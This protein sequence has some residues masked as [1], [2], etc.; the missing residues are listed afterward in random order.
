MIKLNSIIRT[1][2]LILTVFIVFQ[3]ESNAAETGIIKGEVVDQTTGDPLIGARIFVKGTKKGAVANYDGTYRII[4]VPVGEYTLQFSYVGYQK[5]DVTNV[6]VKPDDVAIIDVS[7]AEESVTSDEIVVT[8]KKIQETGAALLKE[9]QKAE[10]VSDAIGAE[11]ISRGGSGDAADAIKK[12]TG[13]TT[14]GGKYVYI[15][16][17]GDR[18]S[19]TQLNGANLPS[20]DPDKK[21]VHL[22]LFPTNLIENITTT[23]TA[24]PD[25]PGD[26]TGGTVDIKTKS[27]PDKFRFSFSMSG[28]YNNNTTGQEILTYPG[29]GTDWLGY[30]NGFREVPSILQNSEVPYIIDAQRIK[31]KEGEMN[32]LG[33]LLDQQSKAFDRVFA[34]STKNAPF[35]GGFSMSVG[36]Q[37][38][39]LDNPFGFL[40]SLGYDR[41]FSS[42]QNGKMGFHSQATGDAKELQEEYVADMISSE[43]EVAWGGMVNLSYG[44]TENN[45]ISFNLMHNRN[46]LSRSVY[47]DGF[48]RYYMVDVESRILK[49]I[50]RSLSSYQLGGEHNMPSVF[51]T[52]IDWSLNYSTN[53]QNE[54]YFRTFDNEYEDLEKQVI[55][56]NDTT[57]QL[58]R[59]YYIARNDNNSY[60]SIYYRD[61]TENLYGGNL[62]IEIPLK[63]SFDIPVKFKVGALY[64]FKD[65]DFDENRYLYRTANESLTFEGDPNQFMLENVGI[66]DTNERFGRYNFGYYIEDRTQPSGF[67]TG[68]QEIMAGYGMIDWFVMDH[69]R[70]VGGV[71]YETTDISAISAD[72]SR[73]MGNLSES[74]IL[75]S[76]NLT[77]QLS[78]EMN[79]RAAYGKTLARPTFREIAPY[80]NYLPIE[81]RTFIGNDTLK[82][83]LIDNVD[84]RWEWFTNPG[85]IISVGGFYKYF[86]NPIELA[87]IN[88]NSNIQPKNVDEA[89]LFG[90]EIEF[91]KN[92]AFLGEFFQNFQFGMNFTYVYSQ[93]NLPEHEFN[94][95]K[96]YDP[97]ADKTR[98]L[99]NQSPYV[100]NLDLTYA[101]YETGTEANLHFNVFGERRAEIGYGTPDYYE[102]PRPDMNFVVSQKF[103]DRFK[104]KFGAKNILDSKY[105]V[106]STFRGTDYIRQSYLLGRTFS[107]GITYSID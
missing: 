40:F 59:Q 44:I 75:P 80:D 32:T 83:T 90:A 31:T 99:Q 67:Y 42:Y 18:Y 98:E 84:L 48:R 14:V 71:R 43:D 45:K 2:F 107:L 33:S 95:R 7:L 96:E 21:A 35:N 94:T 89:I 46:G 86:Q 6:V 93:V 39:V 77:Y 54:P 85:E 9:R 26:F 81:K 103:F 63:E 3:A 8:A 5:T 66:L 79:L 92:L 53:N 30:D 100:V 34:P 27:F 17:L 19:S 82:R 51:G 25:K 60:P 74:D 76:L 47:Q 102:H 101:N 78:D 38:S 52:K 91:R 50:E 57:T 88:A 64:N 58:V 37:I 1:F 49:Y 16:G 11:E 13:A 87:I 24:T 36:D 20:S 4:D 65:R 62:N 105:Y 41:D 73:K 22:D 28:A 70:I 29:S 15:R 72:T 68:E 106:A 56:G 97:N 104:I 69:I 23:K 61:L 12:V 10:A 55:E